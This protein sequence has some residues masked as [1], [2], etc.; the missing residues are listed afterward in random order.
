MSTTG[1]GTGSHWSAVNPLLRDSWSRSRRYVTDPFDALA[2]I[3]LD[4]AH[5]R[6]ARRD[7]PLSAVMPVFGRML[8]QPAA[9]AGLIVAVGDARGR[10]LWVDGARS[11]LRRA[12]SV[13]FQPGADWSERAIGTS[14]PGTALVTGHGVQVHRS[15]HY[16]HP[17]QGFSCTAAPIRCPLT[18]EVLGV[19]DV[20]G[21]ADAVSRHSLPLILAAVD[22]AQ[23]ELRRIREVGPAPSSAARRAVRPHRGPAPLPVPPAAELTILGADRPHL[24]AGVRSAELS[25]RHAEILTLLLEDRGASS[26]VGTHGMT[27]EELAEALYGSRGHAVTLRA[28][29]VRLRRRLA[30]LASP[31][32]LG[33]ASRPYRLIGRVTSDAEQMLEAL[34]DG[35]R[36]TALTLWSGPPLPTSESPGV[37]AL[38]TRTESVLREAMLQ[39]A[40]ADQLWRYLEAGTDASD[41]ELLRTALRILPADSPRRAVLLGRATAAQRA[42][43]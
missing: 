13:A 29:L 32:H 24:R 10:L 23:T 15:E 18:G 30:D 6:E 20:T 33:I 16:A 31:E 40:D 34:A 26:A 12:E 39:D 22:A 19:V 41:E 5:L 37:E 9:D 1:E 25:L 14:A 36:D 17:V 4:D 11:T 38:R 28:E 7:H 42:C 21:G 35:D 27:A 2:P 8:T 43:D 3:A